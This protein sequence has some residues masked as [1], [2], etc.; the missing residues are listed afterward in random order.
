MV[1]AG[2]GPGQTKV[3]ITGPTGKAVPATV[4][5][6]PDVAVAKFTAT[7]PGPHTVQVTYADRPVPNSPFKVCLRKC[8]GHLAHMTDV[9]A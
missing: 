1:T 9:F 3:N 5:Q 4:D 2:A 7:E 6:Q 8:S